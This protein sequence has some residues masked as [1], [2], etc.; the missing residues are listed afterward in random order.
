MMNTESKKEYMN[1]LRPRYA[2]ATKKGK[3]LILDEYCRNTGEDRKHA[4]KKFR[5]KII[6]QEKG[7]RKKRKEFY[8]GHVKVALITMWKIFDNPCG[9]RL[10][11]LLQ[12]ETDRMRKLKELTCSDEIADKLKRITSSTIDK[13]LDHEK[14]IL[15]EKRKYQ[16][17]HN[18]PLK[19]AVPT[20]TSADLDRENPGVVQIDFVEHCGMS[21]H[22]EYINSLSIVDIYSGWWEGDAVMGKGQK[23]ALLAID[24]AKCRSPFAW[25]EMHPDNGSNIMNYHIYKYG[26]KNNIELSRSR[27]YKKN[28]NCF[29]EQKNSTHIRK[30]VGYLRHDTEMELCIL[31]DL[32]LHDLRLY[33]NFFQ[34]VIKLISK[35]RMKGRIKKKYDKSKTPYRRLMESDKLTDKQKKEMTKIYEQ[36][37]PAELK[38]TIDKKLKLLGKIYETKNMPKKTVHS[39]KINTVSVSSLISQPTRVQCHT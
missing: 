39:K 12:E 30:H 34:P 31:Q 25:T 8:D 37:N 35:H 15:R 22:G 18:F 1:T 32:Y 5:Y 11:T 27:P 3:G 19:Q 24:A 17:T 14:E 7:N 9:Q 33:K 36:L 6:L 20:K 38:R 13:K 10:E 4:I 29:V 2:K 28:D 23:R 16:P 21:T 26:I